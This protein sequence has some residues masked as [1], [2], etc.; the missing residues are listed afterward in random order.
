[1]KAVLFAAIAALAMPALADFNDKKPITATV[2]GATPSGYPRTMVEGLNAVVRDVYPGSAV[3]FKP[4]SP[5]GGVLAIADGQADFTATATGTEVRLANE[6]Q[7]PFAKPLKGKFSYVMQLYDNQFIHFLMTKEWAEANGVRSWA[8]I[9]KKKPKMRLAIN[10]PDNP[11][12]TI[13]G[14]Y[15]VMK[16]HGFGINDIEKWGGSYVLGNSQIGLDAITD[17]KADVFMNARNLSDALV[18]DIAGK[19]ELLWIDGDRAT[20]Q[21]AADTFNNKADMV[22]K[23]TYPFMDKDYPTVRMWVALLAGSHVSDEVVYKYVKA[24]AENEKRVQDIGGSL[25]SAFA[26]QKMSVNP[27]N[28]PYHP[29]ALRYYKE[30]GLVK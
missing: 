4:N 3:S 21:K 24:V 17:G 26:T 9:A 14:P 2:T 22:P 16:A 25:K 20:I 23:G 29:G 18:K 8:D 13:G 19:R 11:Q 30:K 27:A 15:E 5:G 12:T 28:L 10:R 7:A 1:M 6:G